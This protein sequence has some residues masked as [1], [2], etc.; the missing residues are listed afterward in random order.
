MQ[1]NMVFVQSNRIL[2]CILYL[3]VWENKFDL[4]YLQYRNYEKGFIS[5]CDTSII[6]GEHWN[7]RKLHKIE[8]ANITFLNNYYCESSK[9]KYTK[10][11]RYINFI[12][13]T[14]WKKQQ[15]NASVK[16]SLKSSLIFM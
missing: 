1:M 16:S 13:L 7:G 15:Q 5:R 6:A 8:N 3:I 14:S 11:K 4:K 2:I 9:Y 10:C 12:V